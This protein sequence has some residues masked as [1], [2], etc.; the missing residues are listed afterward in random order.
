MILSVDLFFPARRRALPPAIENPRPAGTPRASGV[1]AAPGGIPAPPPARRYR[2]AT[3]EAVWAYAFLAIPLIFFLT[4]RI[5]PA[6]QSF[7]LS[8]QTWHVN[9]DMREFVGLQ[10][11]REMLNSPKLHRAL[12]NTLKYAV[13]TVPIQMA[14]G[15]GLALL[16]SSVQHFRGLFRAIF[17]APY[18]TPAAAV[19][20]VWGW[21]YSVNFGIF[22]TFLISLDEFVKSLGLSWPSFVPQPFLTSPDQALYAVSAVII[23]QNVGFQVVIFLAGLLG[24][25]RMYY[26]AARIDGANGWQMFRGITFPLLNPVITFSAVIS[27]IASLQLFDQIVNINFTDQGGPVRSTLSIALY[28]YQEAFGSGRMGYAAAVTVLLF[29]IILVITL[30]QIRFLNRKV[31]Y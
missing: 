2:L 26:E 29:F 7:G 1:P 5:W 9:P 28:M 22:N 18:I 27:T 21:M 25:P 13:I 6:I 31:E 14:L 3:R 17:F 23:W 24:I 30:V 20:W 11:Y 15:L 12:L 10:Y 19:A 16:L 8:L 4:I